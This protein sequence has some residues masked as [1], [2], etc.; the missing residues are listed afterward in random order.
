MKLGVCGSRSITDADWVNYHLD[1]WESQE[2]VDCV[3]SGGAKGVDTLV[4]KWCEGNKVPHIL[5]KPYHLID[6]TQ[7]Y[8]KK[9]FFVRN[10]QIIDN[11]DEMLILWDGVSGGTGW[12]INYAKERGKKLTVIKYDGPLK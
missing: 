10:K 9:F 5:F 11:A 3:L 6:T 1:K 2:D 4:E 8:K 7:P 12:C